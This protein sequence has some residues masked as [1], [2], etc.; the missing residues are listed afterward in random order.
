LRTPATPET[1]SWL[2]PRP[3]LHASPPA[4]HRTTKAEFHK[5]FSGFPTAPSFSIFDTFFNLTGYEEVEIPTIKMNF[6]GVL[7]S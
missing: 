2:I 7:I 4:I 6:E 3:S 1:G 5:R